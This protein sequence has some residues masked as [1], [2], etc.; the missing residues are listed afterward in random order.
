MVVTFPSWADALRKYLALERRH[1]H[2][3]RIS[4]LGAYFIDRGPS[5][6]SRGAKDF[7]G[8]ARLRVGSLIHLPPTYQLNNPRAESQ[9]Y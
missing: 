4:P 5:N 6:L 8:E 1:S 2:R 7:S 3:G 9:T